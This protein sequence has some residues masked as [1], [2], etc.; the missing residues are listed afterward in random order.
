MKL[1]EWA[2]LLESLKREGVALVHVSA[3]R[4]LTGLKEESLN[5]ALWRLER[6][7]LVRRV[8]RGWVC[9]SDC[10]LWEIVKAAFPS[11]YVTLEWALHY[12][13]VLDQAPPMV[14][15][16]WLGKPKIVRGRPYTFE[17]HRICSK[18]YF[19]FDPQLRLAEPEKALLDT[20]HL[21]GYAP[22][23]LNLD[24][25]DKG[26]LRLYARQFPKRVRETLE[27]VLLEP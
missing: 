22:P 1:R 26:K 3:L 7:G 19:G 14:T 17:L 15:L 11:A 13:D 6:E 12:H 20:L 24:L 2:L 16:A 23:D 4:A 27:S 21:R 9:V 25:L 18:L 10:E 8:V 5:V